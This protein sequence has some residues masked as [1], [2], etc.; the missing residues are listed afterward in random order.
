MKINVGD[1]ITYKYLSTDD[2]NEYISVIQDTAELRDCKRMIENKDKLCSIE[3]LKVE[4][5]NWEVV[6]EKKE[7][8]TEEEREFLQG[9]IDTWKIMNVKI[10]SIWKF[11]CNNGLNEYISFVFDDEHIEDMNLPQFRRLNNFKGMT[12]NKQ[13]TLSELGLEE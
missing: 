6:E 9:F 13:Y 12:A 10:K 7:L 1:R 2:K 4:R 3:V 5:P 8:L 11:V